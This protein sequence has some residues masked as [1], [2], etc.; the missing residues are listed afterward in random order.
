MTGRIACCLVASSGPRWLTLA[1]FDLF[2][3]VCI[4]IFIVWRHLEY[5]NRMIDQM[6]F[7]F[8]E[9]RHRFMAHVE[10]YQRHRHAD[11]LAAVTTLVVLGQA[12]LQLF[13]ELQACD[14]SVA[15]DGEWSNALL[16][17]EGKYRL[18]QR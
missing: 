18:L 10:W 1:A 9:A 15:P 3:V 4:V 14:P 5:R 8:L 2:V 7:S 12:S 6:L 16:W 13:Q 17:A 11:V